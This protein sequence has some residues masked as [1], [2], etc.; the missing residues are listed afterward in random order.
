[1]STAYVRNLLRIASRL[2]ATDPILAYELERN[3][4]AVINPGAQT[5]EKHVE[6]TVNV[7]KSLKEE[8]EQADKQLDLDDAKE[9]AKF[10]DDE[11]E[12]QVED[13]RQQLKVGAMILRLAD[14]TAGVMDKVKGL[15]K[16][17]EKKPDVEEKPAGYQ[18]SEREQDEFVEGDRDWTDGGQK[19]EKESKENKEFFEDAKSVQTLLDQVRD[20][21]SRSMVRTIIQDLGDLIER[22]TKLMKGDRKVEDSLSHKDVVVDD[23]AKPAPKKG[24]DTKGLEGI[25]TRYSD[26]LNSIEGDDQKLV[27][28]L[29]EF[30]NKV[31]P[32]IEE[33]RASLAA[34]R[35]R[36]LPLLIRT[37]SSNPRI[38]P[39]ILPVI[40]RWTSK[41]VHVS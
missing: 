38:R 7:L 20:K 29:K 33:D 10:F 6:D 34:N 9:F 21:P 28:T 30:F 41:A 8:L 27:K 37:A 24:P 26:L 4:L 14:D 13:L 39:A 40:K 11:A 36:I 12:A 16:K 22:G 5:F 32:F 35:R 18:M 31:K 2:E 3:A 1:M 25:V 19:V 23:D 17:K 15:F